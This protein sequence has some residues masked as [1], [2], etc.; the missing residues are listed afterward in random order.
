MGAVIDLLLISV[1]SLRLDHCSRVADTCVTTPQFDRQ[2]RDF[3]FSDRC[4]SVASAT[5]PVHMSLCTGL[6]PFEHGLLSQADRGVR[7]QS[8][9]LFAQC[10]QQ[11]VDVSVL[12]EAPE[13][14]TD[15]DLGAPVERLPWGAADGVE[16]IRR[17][18]E[19]PGSASRCLLVHYWAA[20]APYG[21][22]DGKALGETADLVREGQTATVRQRYRAAVE[23]VLE[24]RVAP[25]L[26]SVD[27][28]RCAVLLFGDHGE[29][30]TADELYHGTSVRNRV[31]RVPLYAHLP[32]TPQVF[33]RGEGL[34]SL[35]D[36]Y[37]T[38]CG[39]LNLPRQDEAGFGIDWPTATPEPGRKL[40]AGIRPASGEDGLL[41]SASQAPAPSPLRWCV[42]DEA[43]RL[44]GEADD[45]AASD[46]WT[47]EH[48]WT[49]C[50]VADADAAA[51]A[52]LAAR[53]ELSASTWLHRPLE[54]PLD[55][56]D[57]A[58]RQ[59]LRA[60]GYL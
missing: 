31:L 45:W 48:Q 5:R 33:P 54:E 30:W 46:R 43:F 58:L 19:A 23:D 11:G 53:A 27:L 22:T 14:F 25:V 20:H 52:Y 32:F 17:R 29:C 16:T 18:L 42:F 49:E 47:L 55:R 24:N 40:W 2:T 3:S 56:D 44:S 8:P 4:F 39:I 21:A 7:A 59:R 51:A 28:S 6:Y 38:S 10:R 12:S 26:E 9:R 37:A 1:D 13:I 36:L 50:P 34:L 41:A 15:L 57:T 60:L 35:L